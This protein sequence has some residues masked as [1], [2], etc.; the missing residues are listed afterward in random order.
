MQYLPLSK[1]GCTTC[2]VVLRP[3]RLDFLVSKYNFQ[4]FDTRLHPRVIEYSM[5]HRFGLQVHLTLS[6]ISRILPGIHKP[7][8]WPIVF[9]TNSKVGSWIEVHK[10]LRT[11]NGSTVSLMGHNLN[12][13]SYT[14]SWYQL[15]SLLVLVCCLNPVPAH[16]R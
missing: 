2:E 3:V 14:N 16:S 13:E 12:H 10:F 8:S 7:H 4:F 9:S 11:E 1:G 6:T 15:Y 5:A